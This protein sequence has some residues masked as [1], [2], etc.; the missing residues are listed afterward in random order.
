MARATAWRCR[1]NF[2]IRKPVAAGGNMTD[3]PER[4]Q[5]VETAHSIKLKASKGLDTRQRQPNGFG[6]VS[7]AVAT[8]QA[9]VPVDVP[10]TSAEPGLP[11]VAVDR[12]GLQRTDMISDIVLEYAL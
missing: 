3:P 12:N 7:N 2:N 4:W 9:S 5:C 11:A 1:T 10:Y 8:A 6:A